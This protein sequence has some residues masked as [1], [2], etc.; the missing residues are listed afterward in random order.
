MGVAEITHSREFASV[1]WIITYAWMY[2]SSLVRSGMLLHA[3]VG[4]RDMD[5]ETS[6]R[7]FNREL[8]EDRVMAPKCGSNPKTC[9]WSSAVL[10][11]FSVLTHPSDNPV[12]RFVRLL[13]QCGWYDSSTG[14]TA[15]PQAIGDLILELVRTLRDLKVA[16]PQ[17]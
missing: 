5:Q 2:S 14:G 8:E 6:E 11:S 3:P 12:Q 7:V 10:L 17:R 13:L 1:S 4:R 16:L 9:S 15:Y